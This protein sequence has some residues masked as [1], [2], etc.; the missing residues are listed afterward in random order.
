V[1][2]RL[3]DGLDGG[4][5]RQHRGGEQAYVE[6]AQQARTVGTRA[7]RRKLRATALAF[8]RPAVGSGRVL[9]PDTASDSAGS[10]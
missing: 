7:F 3:G 10:V 8:R 5:D 4:N 1:L 9:S 6:V 2:S